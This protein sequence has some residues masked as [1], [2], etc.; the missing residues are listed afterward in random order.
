MG[1]CKYCG[2]EAGFLKSRHAEC[3]KRHLDGIA[4]LKGIIADC[5]D[6]KDD[7]YGRQGE[8]RRVLDEAH[9]G[10]EEARRVYCESFDSAIER[11]LD[12]GVIDS[13][14]ERA[15]ARFMQFTGLPQHVLNERKSLERM[16]QA[17][18]LGEL[19]Q[20]RVPAPRITV[21]GNFPFLLSK[22]EHMLWLFRDVT[23]M[24]QKVRREM[25]GRTRGVSM[26]IC[27]GVYYRTGGFKGTPV[28]TTY[29][30]R[31]GTGS[32]CLTDKHLYFHCPEK[33]LK[34]PFTRILS[35]DPYANGLGLQKDGA[36][37]RPMFFSGL[38][39]WFCY[40]AISNLI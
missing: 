3:E 18:V 36:N 20:G 8:I 1:K 4:T 19:L 39:S 24:M 38:D 7:F 28:E 13:A 10:E 11:Y 22:D 37:D 12:D 30:D 35:L 14:E 29:M 6:R 23:L 27:K 5:F 2:Q 34:I 17:K 32:V 31:I 26:R 33:T 15:V 9:I 40:N 25:R 16:V 21:A